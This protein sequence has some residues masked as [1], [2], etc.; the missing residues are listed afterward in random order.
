M[1]TLLL[2]ALM[3]AG[4]SSANRTDGVTPSEAAQLNAAADKLDAQS[5]N[6]TRQ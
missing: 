2:V 1:R 3:L 6:A 4:C 5:E